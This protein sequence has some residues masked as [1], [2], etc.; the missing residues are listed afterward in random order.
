MWRC[1]LEVF[2]LVA[3]T[4]CA[5]VPTGHTVADH[6]DVYSHGPERLLWCA[7]DIDN[8]TK[9]PRGLDE[10]SDALMYAKREGTTLHL[11]AHVPGRTLDLSYLDGVLAAA[12]RLGVEMTTYDELNTRAVPGSL[13]LSFDD[14]YLDSWIAIRPMLSKYH[15]RVTF[16]VTFFQAFGDTQRE[17]VAQLAADGHDI[18]YHATKHL[19]ARQFLAKHSMADYLATEITPALDAMRAAG[20][21]TRTFAYP[22]GSRTADTDEALLPYFDHLRGV[23]DACPWGFPHEHHRGTE[24]LSTDDD[25]GQ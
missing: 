19:D 24:Q 10:V 25:R 13:A 4:T 23:A 15:A 9:H 1:G 12:A 14:A 20:Y 21:A 22:R 2:A 17:Q 11:F 5:C 18:E 16:F 6:D 7:F 8:V 3:V